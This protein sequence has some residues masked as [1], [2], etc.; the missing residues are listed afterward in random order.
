MKMNGILIA[1][2]AMILLF[3]GIWI[4][5]I[6]FI[7]NSPGLYKYSVDIQ[8]LENYEPSLITDIIVPLPERNGQP[9]FSDDEL[10]YKTFGSWKSMI[11][12][13]KFGK[14]LAFQSIGR[15]LTDL[16]AEFYKK[17]PEGTV[18]RNITQESLSPVLPLISSTYSIPVDSPYTTQD[19]STIVYIPDTIRPLHANDE[20]IVNLTL[21]ASEGMQH[22]LNGM[23][24]TV[25]V[26]EKI[27]SG[28]YNSTPVVAHILKTD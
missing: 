26:S 9:V 2:A 17:Y 3:L 24:Y 10:Q 25:L 1:I 13:T 20:I 5:G 21:I 14:M 19:Y 23:T 27:P 15:N 12:V 8:G 11:V 18:I 16:N 7:N 4:S 28:I 22:S 6:G